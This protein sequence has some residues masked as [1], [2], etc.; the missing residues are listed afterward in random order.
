MLKGDRLEED[1]WRKLG[2]QLIS[3]TTDTVPGWTGE[4]S[5]DP[6]VMLV[7][8]LAFLAEQLVFRADALPDRTRGRIYEE[9]VPRLAS[10]STDDGQARVTV[11]VGGQ[12]WSKV[13]ALNDAGPSDTVFA[14][15]PD[16]R[17]VFGD[18]AHGRNPTESTVSATVSA[19]YRVGA[20]SG[21]NVGIIITS[22][23]PPPRLQYRVTIDA[24]AGIG[25]TRC[26][27]SA[28]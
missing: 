20:G 6:G 27:E 13:S 5:G 11:Y 24:R 3:V 1:Q 19:S 23:W 8:L 18:G 17:V 7:D 15:T 12:A 4:P 2:R 21:G 25:V 16:G 26:D 28:Q 14:L 22:R 10:L 9:I